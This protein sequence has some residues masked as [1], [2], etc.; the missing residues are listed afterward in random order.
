MHVFCLEM[1][2]CRHCCGQFL[3]RLQRWYITTT[4]VH[5]ASKL[6]VSWVTY[7]LDM[8]SNHDLFFH[9]CEILWRYRNGGADTSSILI[10]LEI[11]HRSPSLIYILLL[12]MYV[13][14]YLLV[15]RYF[16]ITFIFILLQ[17]KFGVPFFPVKNEI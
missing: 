2:R 13:S 5:G 15:V 10:L 14:K 7:S 16:K 9:A 17:T 12:S 1:E 6:A 4:E 11:S 8:N 3:S